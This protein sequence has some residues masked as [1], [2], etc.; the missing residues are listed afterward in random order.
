MT[1]WKD[2]DLQGRQ[3]CRNGVSEQLKPKIIIN[4]WLI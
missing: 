2:N 3:T 1:H 4:K